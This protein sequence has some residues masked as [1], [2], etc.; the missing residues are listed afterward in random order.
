[1]NLSFAAAFPARV[2]TVCADQHKTTFIAMFN[3]LIRTFRS[4]NPS[5]P[6]Q[7]DNRTPDDPPGPAA[8]GPA[9]APTGSHVR[10]GWHGRRGKLTEAMRVDR[11][12]KELNDWIKGS[13]WGERRV[14]AAECI[15]ACFRDKKSELVL[16]GLNLTTL[17]DCIGDLTSL[18]R[19][20]LNLNKLTK[21]PERFGDLTSLT[22]LD[23][24]HNQLTELPERFGELTSLTKLCLLS[25][26][27]TKLPEPFGDLKSL[28][29][30]NLNSNQLTELPER[31]GDLTS[32]IQL[33]LYDN[34][35]TELPECIGELTSLT[36]LHLS[37][38]QLTELPEC[39][40]K[41]PSLCEINIYGNPLTFL[42]D[43]IR[44]IRVFNKWSDSK[45]LLSLPTTRPPSAPTTHA[46]AEAVVTTTASTTLS[47]HS[48]APDPLPLTTEETDA[49]RKL[50]G[51][52]I[53]LA[54]LATWNT[55]ISNPSA[56]L[57]D[58]VRNADALVSISGSKRLVALAK[59]DYE[60]PNSIIDYHRTLTQKL[61]SVYTNAQVAVS[62]DVNLVVAKVV[63]QAAFSSPIS[64]RNKWPSS[65]CC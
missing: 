52:G 40:G 62:V 35:L 63:C 20:E 57:Q 37:N 50:L 13:Q 7:R 4:A 2:H 10:A 44:N 32:L 34:H 55:S 41:M 42:P 54:A 6:N 49:I 30:L 9:A 11:M 16:S 8:A 18:I 58:L 60:P 38:N 48:N 46:S 65:A 59:A 15:L 22:W 39:I 51:S 28:T 25:N 29:W 45:S 64:G 3:K 27:L 14:S 17:P 47:P 12:K 19:L 24:T 33:Y 23:L 36:T 31:F 56:S 1:M 5:P 53:D 26:K 43:E 21:L 61:E